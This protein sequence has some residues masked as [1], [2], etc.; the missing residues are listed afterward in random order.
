MKL[1]R[2]TEISDKLYSVKFGNSEVHKDNYFKY[3]YPL[4]PLER[5]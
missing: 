5:L 2:W 3:I 4:M 1:K